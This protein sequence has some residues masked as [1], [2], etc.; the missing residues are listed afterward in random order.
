MNIMDNIVGYRQWDE[1]KAV[2]YVFCKECTEQENIPKDRFII[3][4]E[5]QSRDYYCDICE[6]RLI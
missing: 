4:N 2:E 3:R 6:D 5:A 1:T